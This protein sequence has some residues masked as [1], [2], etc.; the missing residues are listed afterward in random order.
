MEKLLIAVIGNSNSGK[1][2]TW[3]RMFNGRTKTGK[4][5]RELQLTETEYTS[6]FLVNGSPGERGICITD[7]LED[8]LPNIVLASFKYHDEAVD[9][10]LH[11]KENGY[12]IYCHWLNPGYSQKGR[13][14]DMEYDRVGL[15]N[16]LTSHGCMVGI[17]DGR[18]H[19]SNRVEELKKIIYGWAKTNN[20]VYEYE[21]N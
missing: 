5:E 20:L 13:Y 12:Y 19:P 11:L 15:V 9:H 2:E 7:I 16:Q 1:S 14:A 17:R 10:I 4:H 6:V 18:E 21:M 8:R 3:K